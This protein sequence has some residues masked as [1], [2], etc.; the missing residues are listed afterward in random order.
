[1]KRSFFAFAVALLAAAMAISCGDP[2]VDTPDDTFTYVSTGKSYTL[3]FTPGGI[4][5]EGNPLKLTD[6]KNVYGPASAEFDAASVTAGNVIA[7]TAPSDTTVSSNP[8]II[9]DLAA[10]TADLSFVGVGIWNETGWGIVLPTEII[11]SVSSDGTT[12]SPVTTG[13]NRIYGASDDSSIVTMGFTPVAA[14][15]G[16]YVK[17]EVV[18]DPSVAASSNWNMLSEVL[19]GAGTVPTGYEPL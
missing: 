10:V 17:I 19:V 14:V 11:V 3:N 16:R 1:M 7:L 6:G 15:T 4:Y 13:S 2:P 18:L 9:V 5:V 8:T 12:Y